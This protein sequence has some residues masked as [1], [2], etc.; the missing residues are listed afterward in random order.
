[1]RDMLEGFKRWAIRVR[2]GDVLNAISTVV[3][4]VLIWVFLVLPFV[5]WVGGGT[6]AQLSSLAL[7]CSAAYLV[8][9]R[10]RRK[11]AEAEQFMPNWE[12]VVERNTSKEA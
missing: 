12:K 3:I 8:H 9:L 1:M 5:A 7:V 4:L 11:E 6:V 10:D 2:A